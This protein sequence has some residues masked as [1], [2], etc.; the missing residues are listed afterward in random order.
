[1]VVTHNLVISRSQVDSEGDNS[2][3]LS[4]EALHL[5]D[6]FTHAVD[7][8]TFA[9]DPHFD[10]GPDAPPDID[11]QIRGLEIYF[12]P[13][14][15]TQLLIDRGTT[16]D[17]PSSDYSSA[18]GPQGDVTDSGPFEVAPPME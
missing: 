6:F 15:T 2:L 5:T 12:V 13:L 16:T 14:S 1:M 10:S 11:L 7:N 4:T 17:A 9:L 3:T 18:M 8:A